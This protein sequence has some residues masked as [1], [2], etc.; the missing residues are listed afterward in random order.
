MVII[1]ILCVCTC[2]NS[3]CVCLGRL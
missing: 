3:M 2:Y 1:A